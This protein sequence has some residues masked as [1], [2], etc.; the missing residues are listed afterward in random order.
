[1]EIALEICDA[2]LA[3]AFALDSKG[4]QRI[5]DEALFAARNYLIG[6]YGDPSAAS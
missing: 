2:I 6:F 5:I 3:R 1:M 4:D